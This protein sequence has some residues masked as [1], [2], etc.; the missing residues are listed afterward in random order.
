M[1]TLPQ[2]SS[3]ARAGMIGVLLGCAGGAHADVFWGLGPGSRVN[4]IS[5]DGS[6]AV[7]RIGGRAYRWVNSTAQDLNTFGDGSTSTAI[8]VSADGSVVVGNAYNGDFLSP[9]TMAFRWSAGGTQSFGATGGSYEGWGSLGVS[10]DGSVVV[11]RRGFGPGA[12]AFGADFGPPVSNGRSTAT[13]VSADGSVIVG[14]SR[15]DA[16]DHAEAFRWSTAG[17]VTLLGALP[18]GL[19]S[20]ATAISGDGTHVIGWS[21]SSAGRQAFAW[22]G[23]GMVPLGDLAGGAFDSIALAT[24]AD[25]AIVVGTA[26]SDSGPVAFRWTQTTGIVPLKDWLQGAGVNLPDWQLTSATGISADGLTMVGN[27][28]GPGGESQAWIVTVPAP[29]AAVGLVLGSTAL[30]RRARR[31]AR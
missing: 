22:S 8:G 27:G 10:A 31:H 2:G 3:L 18:G 16:G 11:G 13:G 12:T 24:S 25:G 17:G 28:I 6:T 29:G 15:T 20:A 5:A 19:E 26:T 21:Q 7:G 9:D 14:Q 23:A 4:A 1:R 30:S